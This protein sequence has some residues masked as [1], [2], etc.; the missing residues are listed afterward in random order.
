MAP[1]FG[2]PISSG[3]LTGVLLV[4]LFVVVWIIMHMSGWLR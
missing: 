1:I 2:S 4:L 3:K